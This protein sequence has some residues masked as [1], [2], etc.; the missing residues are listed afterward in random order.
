MTSDPTQPDSSEDQDNVEYTRVY[1]RHSHT[2]EVPLY[3]TLELPKG[4]N[5]E[6]EVEY[7]K[8]NFV[9]SRAVR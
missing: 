9:K 4:L 7:T 3:S 6:E 8:V 2:Q 1:F 5:Q